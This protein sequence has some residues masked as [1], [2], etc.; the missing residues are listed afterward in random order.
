MRKEKE[1]RWKII[2]YS[3]IK[4]ILINKN[5]KKKSTEM[6]V[7]LFRN[8]NKIL[9][10]CVFNNLMMNYTCVAL[11]SQTTDSEKLFSCLLFNNWI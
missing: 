5:N 1:K 7:V 4:I 6:S 2:L 8:I 9:F 11:A 10:G 3:T